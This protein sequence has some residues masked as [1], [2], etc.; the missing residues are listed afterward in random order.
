M[1]RIFYRSFSAALLFF[2][3]LSCSLRKNDFSPQIEGELKQWHK[4]T[5]TFDGPESSETDTLNPFLDYW[6]EMIFYKNDREI[7]IPGHFAAD[8]NSAETGSDSGNKWRV[9]FCPEDFGLW[10][11]R[12]SFLSG[13]NVAV[14]GNP[15]NAE[16][17]YFDGTEGEFFVE[18]SDKTGKDFR[19]H[20]RIQ[21]VG[22]HHLRFQGSGKYF[23]KGGADSPENFLAYQ[24]FD[25]T[26][27]RGDGVRRLGEAGPNESLHTYRPHLQDW[28]EGDP[29]WMNGKGKGIIGALNYLSSEGINSVYMLTNNVGGD[30]K[31]VYPWTEYDGDFTRFD[32][33][34][35]DQWEIVFSHMDV[36]GIMC[37]FVTQET[38]N[39]LLLDSGNLGLTRKL[40]YR[41]LISRF[42]HHLG[43]TWNLGEENGPAPWLGFGQNEQQRKDMAKYIKETDPYDNFV[44]VHTL[45]DQQLR[46]ELLDQLLGF[47]YLDGPSLQTEVGIVH[48]ET[49]K[50]RELSKGRGRPWVVCSDEIGPADT[51]VVPDDVDPDHDRIRKQVLW[52]NLM[53]GGGGVEWYFGYNYPNND[54]NCEDWRSRSNLWKQTRIAVDF[55]QDHLPFYRMQ[56]ADQFVS[57]QANYALVD[58]EEILVVYIPSGGASSIRVNPLNV[59]T[60]KWFD[61]VK[62]G[63]LNEE[64]TTKYTGKLDLN[65]KIKNRNTSQ[66][67]V[68]LFNLME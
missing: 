24:E 61:P 32:I 26:I 45:P 25:G 50:W 17:V 23:L 64:D 16:H 20:G 8:G 42:S 36:L 62:G 35:L 7:K 49:L 68:A 60:L 37:H 18:P 47:P 56:P 54:L 14:V 67:W 19:A 1:K 21:Y 11:Y 65:F 9:I 28:K 48:A 4:I 52:G 30:G 22:Q 55:F 46:D 57:P 53:A 12:V 66:D 40:Y 31:D 34:K 3:I 43:I 38:E 13:K 51:G 44:V 39:E 41:E 63:A 15:E 5:F 58:E 6:M 27:Y 29:T 59:Y 33:S 10:N 2:I